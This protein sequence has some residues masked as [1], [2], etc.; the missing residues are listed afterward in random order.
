MPV[1]TEGFLVA[2]AGMVAG[3]GTGPGSVLSVLAPEGVVMGWA[4]GA[5]AAVE[6]AGTEMGVVEVLMVAKEVSGQRMDSPRLPLRALRSCSSSCRSGSTWRTCQAGHLT[7][8]VPEAS[9]TT[10][11]RRRPCCRSEVPH[12]RVVLSLNPT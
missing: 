10:Q 11:M 1:A 5:V 12:A 6:V 8:W 9:H 4:W 2:M 7:Q 3:G